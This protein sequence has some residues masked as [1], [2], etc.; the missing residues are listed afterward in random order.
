MR[1]PYIALSKVPLPCRILSDFVDDSGTSLF[2]TLL[3]LFYYYNPIKIYT[4]QLLNIK[5][6]FLDGFYRQQ[7]SIFRGGKCFG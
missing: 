1:I 7:K 6:E 2:G 4:F 3:R 5:F